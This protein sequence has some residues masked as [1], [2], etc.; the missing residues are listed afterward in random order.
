MKIQETAKKFRTKA[1]LLFNGKPSNTHGAIE[2]YTKAICCAGSDTLELGLSH[3]NRGL[4]L[5]KV[6]RFMVN[7]RFLVMSI[8]IF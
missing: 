7:F 5:M 6:N 4:A 3:A 2:L 1:N 8:S